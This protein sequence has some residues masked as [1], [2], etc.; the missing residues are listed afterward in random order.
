MLQVL[1]L[2]DLFTQFDALVESADVYKV[3]TIGDAYMMVSGVPTPNGKRHVL[4]IARVVLGF[5]DVRSL[6]NCSAATKNPRA[7]LADRRLTQ[8]TAYGRRLLCTNARRLAHR[9]RGGG[10]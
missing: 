2:N 4:E 9:R 7:P 10:R 8:C 1:L 3:E 6:R 5:F